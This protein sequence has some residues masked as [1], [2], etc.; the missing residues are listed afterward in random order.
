MFMPTPE[1]IA[2]KIKIGMES[3]AMYAPDAPGS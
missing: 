3:K 2:E 1:E